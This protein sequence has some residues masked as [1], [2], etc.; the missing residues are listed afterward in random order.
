[1]ISDFIGD[2]LVQLHCRCLAEFFAGGWI[3]WNISVFI[4]MSVFTHHWTI[5]H[6]KIMKCYLH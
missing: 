2:L 4:I 1:M 3:L 6:L 5:C